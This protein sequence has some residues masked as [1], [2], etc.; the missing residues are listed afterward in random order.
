MAECGLFQA[1]IC[2][3]AGSRVE[4]RTKASGGLEAAAGRLVV[5]STLAMIA[6]GGRSHH[7]RENAA[8]PRSLVSW[9]GDDFESIYTD[10]LATGKG[11]RPRLP[12]AG[13]TAQTRW[14][15]ERVRFRSIGLLRASST[16]GRL[17]V[18]SAP[19]VASET[20]RS[21]RRADS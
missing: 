13:L 3:V 2:L 5:Y 7:P 17:P 21:R 6:D 16:S 15:G 12:K 11:I 18:L 14:I 20:C 4:A 9:S 10:A 19:I 8:A 1:S